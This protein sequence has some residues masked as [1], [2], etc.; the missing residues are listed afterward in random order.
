MSPRGKQPSSPVSKAEEP[1][2]RA[3]R[4]L[5]RPAFMSLLSSRGEPIQFGS[6]QL[7]FPEWLRRV[8]LVGALIALSYI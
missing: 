2:G 6:S 5:L 7:L 1:V 8:G 4:D 3:C